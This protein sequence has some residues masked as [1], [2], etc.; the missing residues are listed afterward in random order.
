M[1]KD[2]KETFLVQY[3]FYHESLAESTDPRKMSK[4]I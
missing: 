3:L 2:G 1:E 4:T